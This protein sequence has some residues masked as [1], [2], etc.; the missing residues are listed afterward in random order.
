LRASVVLPDTYIG[1]W[2]D[3]NNAIVRSNTLIRVDTGAV[4]QVTDA[5]LLADLRQDMLS[6]GMAESLNRL[7][8]LI[9]LLLSLPLWALAL[10]AALA[11]RPRSLLRGVVLRGNRIELD[12]LGIRQRRNFQSWEWGT[13]VPVLRYLPR[14]LA[15]VSGHLRL[16][17]TLPLTPEQAQRRTED[18]EF[19]GDQV[20]AGMIGPTVLNLSPDAPEEERLLSDAFYARQRTALTDLRCLLKGLR[21]LFSRRAW[22]RPLPEAERDGSGS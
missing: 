17:G 5:F 1:E 20:P 7:S 12:E 6:T 14:V 22:G 15:V 11:K 10:L 4:L 19:L 18:W 2:V 16:V 21:L 3:I 8:G 9:L 13:S